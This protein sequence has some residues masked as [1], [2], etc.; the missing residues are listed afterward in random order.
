M[1][2]DL[3]E[4]EG[5]ERNMDMMLQYPCLEGGSSNNR[6]GRPKRSRC[7]ILDTLGSRG[8][9]MLKARCQVRDECTSLEF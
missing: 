2:I 4:R 6:W 3:R 7:F 1:L 8:L 5:R 9:Q